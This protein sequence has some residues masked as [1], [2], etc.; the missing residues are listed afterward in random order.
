VAIEPLSSIDLNRARKREM[1]AE[2][3]AVES[4]CGVSFTDCMKLS[5]VAECREVRYFDKKGVE[6]REI[7]HGRDI[8]KAWLSFQTEVLAD[9]SKARLDG[10]A[11]VLAAKFSQ[12]LRTSYTPRYRRLASA[13]DLAWLDQVTLLVAKRRIM[14]FKYLN[15]A[16]EAF[17]DGYAEQLMTLAMMLRQGASEMARVAHH[18]AHGNHEYQQAALDRLMGCFKELLNTAKLEAR[19]LPQ[20]QQGD[21]RLIMPA[22][23]DHE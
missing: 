16:N 5:G 7:I 20:L 9:I 14:E 21:I 6:K 11:D 1:Y 19:P 3:A 12:W 10:Y 8:Y 23:G 17:A 15:R 22:E 2:R 4:V 18:G 13:D